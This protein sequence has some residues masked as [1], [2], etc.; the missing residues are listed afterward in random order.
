MERINAF[1]TTPQRHKLERLVNKT[2]LSMAELL[3]RAIDQYLERLEDR[4]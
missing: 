4:D 2:G 1:V 3:R